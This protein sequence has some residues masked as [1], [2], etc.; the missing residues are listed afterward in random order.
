MPFVSEAQNYA[1]TLQ[2]GSNERLILE[3]LFKNA[4][5]RANSKTWSDIDTY[6]KQNGVKIRQQTFQQGLLKKSREG[7]IFIGSN[8][9]GLGRGYFLIQDKADA[10]IMRQRYQH[11]IQ[12][13]Q[14]HLN[15]LEALIKQQWP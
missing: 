10:E 12:V 11:R 14:E 3:Y 15:Q 6:L 4:L 1:L 7:E 13:E 9:H 2:A 5:G 8:D